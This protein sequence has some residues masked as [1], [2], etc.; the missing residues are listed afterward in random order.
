[1][2]VIKGETK[3][4][5]EESKLTLS[6]D[7]V[8]ISKKIHELKIFVVYLFSLMPQQSKKTFIREYIR[9]TLTS[10]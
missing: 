10:S 8:K 3:T 4:D 1:M 6:R 7:V 9:L 5:S 2:A